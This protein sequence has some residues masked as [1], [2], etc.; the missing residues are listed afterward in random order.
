MSRAVATAVLTP[1]AITQRVERVGRPT[2]EAREL[3][4]AADDVAVQQ[5]RP[6][7][8]PPAPRP[9]AREYTVI[10][11][12]TYWADLAALDAAVA[13][14]KAAGVRRATRSWLIRVAIARL[15]LDA[16]LAAELARTR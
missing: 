5:R 2:R 11:I 10:C 3:L 1:G 7:D 16:V 15:D 9:H 8:L 12:S 13:R 4:L 14:L 6:E